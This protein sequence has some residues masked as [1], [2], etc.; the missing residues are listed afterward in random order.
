MNRTADYLSSI[1]TSSLPAAIFAFDPGCAP[2]TLN[3]HIEQSKHLLCGVKLSMATW[4]ISSEN[5]LLT[6]IGAIR[7]AGLTAVA[8]GGPF[9]IAAAFNKI[10]DYL[11]LCSEIGFNRIEAGEGFTV[12]RLDPERIVRIANDRG[13]KVQFELGKKFGGAFKEE[14]TNDLCGKIQTWL[15]AGAEQVVVEAREDAIDV[16]VFDA[17]GNLNSRLADAIVGAA[18]SQ[19]SRVQFEAPTKRSQFALLEHLGHSVILSN[20]RLEE[21]LRV[22]VFRRGLHSRSFYHATLRPRGPAV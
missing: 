7:Q 17:E 12:G 13:L 19:L 15:A 1:G 21:I 16:G 18:G 22:E 10:D 5:A 4:Q 20:V 9:E 8:G 11:D 6:K 2:I 14:D 3:S